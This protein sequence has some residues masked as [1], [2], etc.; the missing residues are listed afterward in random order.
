MTTELNTL[1][2]SSAVTARPTSMTRPYAVTARPTSM[3]RPCTVTARPTHAWTRP[4]RTST[5]RT[6]PGRAALTLAGYRSLA[7]TRLLHGPVELSHLRRLQ[8]R[9]VG[10]D[11]LQAASAWNRLPRP[12]ESALARLPESP[13]L[14]TVSRGEALLAG[15]WSAWLSRAGAAQLRLP[16][17]DRRRL[18]RPAGLRL[19]RTAR[20]ELTRTARLELTR[21]ARL[22]VTRAA[23]ARLARTTRLEL[24]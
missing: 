20:L 24:T 15:S 18:S 16:W 12:P 19:P 21:T 7:R 3:T 4:A 13:A 5:M 10:V 9:A 8:R 22:E 17:A 1:T 6:Q 23:L 14:S 11:R 2:G